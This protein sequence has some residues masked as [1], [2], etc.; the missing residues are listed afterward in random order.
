[1]RIDFKI[2]RLCSHCK[3]LSVQSYSTHHVYDE[4]KGGLWDGD[5]ETAREPAAYF[6]F[7]CQTCDEVL[8]Y[9]YQADEFNFEDLFPCKR[10]GVESMTWNEA[11]IKQNLKC[12]HNFGSTFINMSPK[13]FGRVISRP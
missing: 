5:P 1:V 2:K 13:L 3:H 4:S 12:G 8:L 10:N 6:I 9:H 11:E 7:I